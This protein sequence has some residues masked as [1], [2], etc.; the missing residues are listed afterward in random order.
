MFTLFNAP[1]PGESLTAEP[2][3]YPWENPMM[4][5][6]PE[7]AMQYHIDRISTPQTMDAI[8]TLLQLGMPVRAMTETMMT[9][10]TMNGI[11]SPDISTIIAPIIHEQIK[12]IADYAGVEYEEGFDEPEAVKQEREREILKALVRKEMNKKKNMSKESRQ[13]MEQSLETLSVPEA[14]Y[15]TQEADPSEE[16]PKQGLMARRAM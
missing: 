6:D 4:H 7:K 2:R 12:Q 14:E 13:V 9:N 11:H 5:V 15:S 1:V 8:L 10:A 3:N 16:Q